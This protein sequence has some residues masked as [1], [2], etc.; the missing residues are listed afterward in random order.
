MFLGKDVLAERSVNP[1]VFNLASY[2]ETMAV[3]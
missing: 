1:V 3:Q 2:Q